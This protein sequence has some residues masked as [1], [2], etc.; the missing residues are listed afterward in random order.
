MKRFFSILFAGYLVLGFTS[1]SVATPPNGKGK[2]I[3]RGDKNK[4]SQQRVKRFARNVIRWNRRLKDALETATGSTI[5]E[6]AQKYANET[7][8]DD[9]TLPDFLENAL[10]TSSCDSDSDDD[11]ISDDD[12]FDDDE[13]AGDHDE[14]EIEVENTITELSETTL[15]VGGVSFVITDRTRWLDSEKAP[16]SQSDFAVGSC[17]EVEGE[18][19]A[20]GSILAEKVKKKEERKCS[21]HSGH[22]DDHDEHDESHS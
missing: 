13:S 8:S 19:E 12:E 22:D 17:V 20:D 2:K 4:G 6:L 15:V 5:T 16:L 11:G 3:E 7:H 14:H 21:E 10:G 9:D 18:L 1:L